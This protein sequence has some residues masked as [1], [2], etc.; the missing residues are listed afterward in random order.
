MK[1]A[2]SQPCREYRGCRN[3][4]G[5]GVAPLGPPAF[6]RDGRRKGNKRVLVHRW[7]VEQ[8]EGPLQPGEVVR[9]DCDNPPCFLYEHLLRGTPGDNAR[10]ASDRGAWHKLTAEQV[11][12]VRERHAAGET[13]VALGKAYGVS[14][15]VIY[16]AVTGKRAR[17]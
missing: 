17:S 13:K 10:D 3:P 2:M 8:V 14:R 6:H 11:A 15:A 5:Y 16:R 1:R 7:V 4:D 12:E 9:H